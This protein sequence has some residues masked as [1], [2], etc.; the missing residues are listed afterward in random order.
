MS[1]A[2]QCQLM[3]TSPITTNGWLVLDAAVQRRSFCQLLAQAAQTEKQAWRVGAVDHGVNSRYSQAL[4]L[5][6]AQAAQRDTA[7]AALTI[8]R[9]SFSEALPPGAHPAHTWRFTLNV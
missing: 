5:A 9:I 4:A 7:A 3:S 6:F 8:A 1:L 2:H